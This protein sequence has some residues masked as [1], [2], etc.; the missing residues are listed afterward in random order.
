M[1][2]FRKDC[3]LCR[4]FN[5]TADK[6]PPKLVYE[7]CTKLKATKGSIKPKCC[8]QIPPPLLCTGASKCANGPVLP[9]GTT[10]RGFNTVAAAPQAGGAAAMKMI[11]FGAKCGI[12][13]GLVFCACKYG[14]WGTADETQRM[15]DNI[16]DFTRTATGN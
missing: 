7:S 4:K 13:G 16:V 8:D 12:A 6:C 15:V 2:S 5:P 11:K 3:K 1:D 9:K 14:L 10:K